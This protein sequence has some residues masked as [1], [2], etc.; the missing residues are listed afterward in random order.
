MAAENDA[1]TPYVLVVGDRTNEGTQVF[2]ITDKQVITEVTSVE[3]V[4]FA[5]MSAFF[6]F[7]IRYPSWYNNFYMFMEVY[8][9]KL[10]LTKASPNSEALY[11]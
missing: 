8:T 4:P 7:N 6:V 10:S 2:L 9:L 5:L 11:R 3:D 1:V